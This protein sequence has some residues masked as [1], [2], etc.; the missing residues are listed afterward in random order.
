MKYVYLIL[1]IFFF[2]LSAIQNNNVLVQQKPILDLPIV[3]FLNEKPFGQEDLN[4]IF[5]L[6]DEVYKNRRKKKKEKMAAILWGF[7]NAASSIALAASGNVQ[8][9]VGNF[10]TNIF[11]TAAQVAQIDANYTKDPEFVPLKSHLLFNYMINLVEYVYELT[12]QDTS[13]DANLMRFP[14]LMEVSKLTVYAERAAW[15]ASKILEND[16]VQT[17][18]KEILDYLQLYLHEKV[19]DFMSFI[20]EKLLVNKPIEVEISGLR[21]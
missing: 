6:S 8:E 16:F 3:F 10:V 20:R 15:V 2:P 21:S 13:R 17:F 1:L 4:S 18:L 14:S 5:N 7:A 12:S 11:S 19:D 9:G